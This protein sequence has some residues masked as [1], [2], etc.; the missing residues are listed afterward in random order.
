MNDMETV[1]ALVLAKT[2]AD[3]ALAEVVAERDRYKAVACKALVD[4]TRLESRVLRLEVENRLLAQAAGEKEVGRVREHLD[5]QEEV[6]VDI[7]PIHY[8]LAA[9]QRRAE[10]LPLKRVG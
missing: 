5:G 8:A 9:G 4:V 3:R 10:N 7:D 6:T 2:A 1:E